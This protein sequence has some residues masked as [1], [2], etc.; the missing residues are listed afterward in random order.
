M[1]SSPKAPTKDYKISDLNKDAKA[2][3]LSISEFEAC[4]DSGEGMEAVKSDIAA[5]KQ[6]EVRSTPTYILNGVR[7]SGVLSP[8]TFNGLSDALLD[9]TEHRAHK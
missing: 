3:G 2:L 8:A 6:I 4:M 5:G 9:P 7:I 1:S